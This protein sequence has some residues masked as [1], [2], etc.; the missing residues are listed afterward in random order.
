MQKITGDETPT[1]SQ[2]QEYQRFVI[3]GFTEDFGHPTILEKQ[4]LLECAK[5]S[6]TREEKKQRRKIH[7][8]S[9]GTLPNLATI[10]IKS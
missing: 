7:W 3:E 4:I 2:I 1:V 8:C 5:K 10:W 9:R 6:I